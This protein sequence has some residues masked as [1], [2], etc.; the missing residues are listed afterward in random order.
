MLYA[1]GMADDEGAP[2][3]GQP[4][5]AESP[6]HPRS[7][8]DDRASAKVPTPRS[9]ASTAAPEPTAPPRS[10]PSSTAAGAERPASHARSHTQ[11]PR[12]TAAGAERPASHARSHTQPPRSSSRFPHDP[13]GEATSE[14][15]NRIEGLVGEAF[16]RA[17][18][19]GV[20]AGMGTLKMADRVRGVVDGVVDDVP[21][22]KEIAGYVFSQVDETKNALVRVVAREVREFLDATDVATELQRALTS[23]SFEIKTEVRF[24]PNEAGGIR[25]SVKARAAPKVTRKRRSSA[26]PP[27]EE[28]NEAST[29]KS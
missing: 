27:P 13:A 25:P 4:V 20:E 24:I 7:Q 22:P 18:E 17:L 9:P 1:S 19:K 15:R 26:P 23:L 11:P 8:P 3:D 10:G 6:G 14:R 21:L 12:S 28:P 16:R 2:R 29:D 5:T